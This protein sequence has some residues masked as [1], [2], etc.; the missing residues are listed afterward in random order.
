MDGRN[1]APL[2]NHGKPWLVG[3]YRGI[4]SFQGFLGGARW[5]A[6]IHSTGSK[7]PLWR[8]SSCATR[9]AEGRPDLRLR[10]GARCFGR[11][12]E[13][14]HVI[15]S[16]QARKKKENRARRAT[17]AGGEVELKWSWSWSGIQDLS[18]VA[19]GQVGWSWDV[20][21]LVEWSWCD[22]RKRSKSCM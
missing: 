4:A 7:L 3:V 14:V 8:F 11:R 9:Q 18:G 12:Q 2:G 5:I 6:S 19:P 13:G 21:L 10:G 16:L 15:S 22:R 20:G 17:G 1:P